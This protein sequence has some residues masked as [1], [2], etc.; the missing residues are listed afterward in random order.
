MAIDDADWERRLAALWARIDDLDDADF[1]EQMAALAGELRADDPVGVFERAGAFDSTGRTDR[2]VPL[3]REAI[4]LGLRGFR[5][6]QAVIQLASSLRV[7]GEAAEAVALLENE[8]ARGSDGLDDALTAFLALAMADIGR[9]R[10]ALSVALTA[11]APH[12]LRYQ[13]SV[14]D[15]ARMLGETR[16]PEMPAPESEDTGA[17]DTGT[18]ATAD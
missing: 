1:L 13:R 9:E 11:L 7:L 4:A 3:Y 18:Q 8:K 14:T 16:N 10:E 12:L 15:Y 2:A 17:Q 6:R 5:R